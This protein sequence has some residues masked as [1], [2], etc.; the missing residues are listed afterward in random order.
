MALYL[1]AAIDKDDTNWMVDL[2]MVTPDDNRQLLS[3]GWLKAGH[4]ALDETRSRPYEPVHPRQDP[5]PV[6]PGKVESYAIA[7]LPTA[8]VF[9]KGCRLELTIRNQDDIFSRLGTW[10]VY[11]LPFMQ[12]VTHEIHFGDS[13]LLIPHI[14]VDSNEELKV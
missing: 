9:S 13:H 11:M 6:T 14:P 4:R 7:L 3:N 10:G 12:T 5:V 1:D 8:C 2:V